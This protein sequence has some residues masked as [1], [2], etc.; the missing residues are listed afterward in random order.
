MVNVSVVL[1]LLGLLL[2]GSAEVQ[3][4][5]V[6]QIGSGWARTKVNAVIFRRNAVC[7]HGQRQIAAFYDDAGQ[8]I[9]AERRHG[10]TQWRL[11]QTGLQ[12]RPQD[13]HNVISLALDGQGQ[14]HLVWDHHGHPLKYCRT[15][16][17]GSLQLQSAEVMV[18]RNEERVT[19]PEFYQLPDGDLLFFYRDGGSGNGNL[20]LN[21]Y[22]QQTGRWE[23]LHDNLIDGEGQR[24]AYWQVCVG[25]RGVIHLSWVWRE[26]ANVVTNHDIAYAKSDDGGMTWKTTT[27]ELYR[28]P[29]TESKAEYAVRIPMNSELANQTSMAEDHLGNPCI[30]NFWRDTLD[31]VPQ[32]RLVY[33]DGSLWK[34]QQVGTRTLNFSRRGGGTQRP[35][36]SR[37]LILLRSR[38]EQTGAVMLF[39]DQERGGGITAAVSDD[40]HGG[41]WRFINLTAQPVG[42]ADPMID[43]AVWSDSGHVHLLSQMTGQGD[44]ETQ[45]NVGPQPIR[46]IE[47]SPGW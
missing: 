39:R 22:R 15:V 6:S 16:E 9:L 21:R 5:Q 20:V 28:M 12:G 31:G 1:C 38:P 25:A 46:L 23:R 11:A 3:G 47:W 37:P 7:S 2:T 40:L 27:G 41:V 44:E 42:Q 18:G 32:Y 14:L 34:T 26:T 4:Q 45:E 35:P 24:N 8:V 17:P 43:P 10:E 19:Y 13:A 33:H 30:A 36:V 29:I